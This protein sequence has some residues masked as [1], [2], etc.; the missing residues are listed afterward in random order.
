MEDYGYDKADIEVEF[1]V[2]L[3]RSK[4]RVDL[5][6]FPPEAPHKQ[7]KIYIVVECKREEVRPADRDNGVEQL[8][9]YMSACMNARFGMWVGAEL[10]VWEKVDLTG[11]RYDLVEVADL[12]RF[13][14]DAPQ[15][16]TFAELV[17]AQEELISVFRRCHNY[18]Y[19]N[20]R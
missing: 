12:P 17:P 11:G 8:K 20:Q 3:G 16:L 2:N 15:P 10:Q 14:F 6:I 5:A 19:G 13:G 18:I 7:E 1:T 4:K 9:S